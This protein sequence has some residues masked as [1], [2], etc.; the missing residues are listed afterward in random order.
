MEIRI[1]N[2]ADAMRYR[3]I[4]LQSLQ[5]HPE[6]FLSTYEIEVA[7]PIEDTEQKLRPFDDRFT[8]GA[9]LQDEL[10]G[11][12]TFIKETHPKTM[13]K[14]NIYAMYVSSA[15][16]EQKIG[17]SL[18]EQLIHIA[19]EIEGLEQ[20][21]LTVISKNIAAKKLYLSLGFRVYGI[22]KNALKYED[23]YWDEEL[24]VLH[25]K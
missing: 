25:L 22:E 13:H 2:Q 12:V 10:V 21:G 24:M 3:K 19:S 6:A 20:I 15:Y 7:Q 23:E 18:I 5:E 17:K 9:F 14:G 1:L 8:I 4:R 16:R 11:T